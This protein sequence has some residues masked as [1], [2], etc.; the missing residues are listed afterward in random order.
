MEAETYTSVVAVLSV[1]LLLV[2]GVTR[3]EAARLEAAEP[4][5]TAASAP[6][7]KHTCFA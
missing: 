4:I 2:R 6:L 5:A 7:R 3:E 1:A